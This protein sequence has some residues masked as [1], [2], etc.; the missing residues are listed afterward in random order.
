V[1]KT[2]KKLVKCVIAINNRK[3]YLTQFAERLTK[4]PQKKNIDGNKSIDEDG[5]DEHYK[6][7]DGGVISNYEAGNEDK[8]NG[9]DGSANYEKC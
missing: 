9:E 3:K 8:S 5:C 2:I 1:G 4:W 6:E 7:E